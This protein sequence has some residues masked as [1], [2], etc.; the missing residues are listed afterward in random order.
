M[1]NSRAVSAALGPLCHCDPEHGRHVSW[2]P[3]AI[4]GEHSFSQNEMRPGSCC[5]CKLASI[6]FAHRHA[7]GVRRIC[8]RQTL[9]RERNCSSANLINLVGP[10]ASVLSHML[11][12]AQRVCTYDEIINGCANS[13]LLCVHRQLFL[14]V[15]YNENKSRGSAR[16]I[17]RRRC[18]FFARFASRRVY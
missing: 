18:F 3:V 9:T 8:M 17:C 7:A 12:P 14:R 16:Q 2:G 1:H 5:N 10:S 13:E 15:V 4:R 6:D 11:W